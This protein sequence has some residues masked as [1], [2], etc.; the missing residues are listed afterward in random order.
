MTKLGLKCTHCNPRHNIHRIDQFTYHLL[1][2]GLNRDQIKEAIF[3]SRVELTLTVMHRMGSTRRKFFCRKVVPQY[4]LICTF[5]RIQPHRTRQVHLTPMKVRFRDGRCYDLA[6]FNL[7]LIAAPKMLRRL[8]IFDDSSDRYSNRSLPKSAWNV[9]N[10]DQSGT[11]T[12]SAIL[13]AQ[14]FPS[15]KGDDCRMYT[16]Q[17]LDVRGLL[18]LGQYSS[19]IGDF[20][21]SCLRKH[22]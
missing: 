5:P 22:F 13:V 4:Q 10:E 14:A 21:E 16:V 9:N 20:S 7:L 12:Q 17:Y 2:K 11:G 8:H 18:K 19:Q 3:K 15:E 1:K 6:W